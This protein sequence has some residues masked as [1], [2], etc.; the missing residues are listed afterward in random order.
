MN[1]LIAKEEDVV[2][3]D[4]HTDRWHTLARAG[5]CVRGTEQADG[6]RGQGQEG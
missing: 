5:A 2:V 4:V 3:V 1:A 6:W